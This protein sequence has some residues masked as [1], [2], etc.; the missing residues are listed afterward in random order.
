[1]PATSTDFN[2]G[3]IHFGLGSRLQ[4][5]GGWETVNKLQLAASPGVTQQPGCLYFFFFFFWTTRGE[6]SKGT[7]A[8]NSVGKRKILNVFE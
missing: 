6:D 4:A 7:E 3:Y 2:N 8:E 5:P 1:M